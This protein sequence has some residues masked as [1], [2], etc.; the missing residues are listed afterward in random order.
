MNNSRIAAAAM[1]LGLLTESLPGEPATVSFLV[2]V[3]LQCAWRC[4]PHACQEI[5][6]SSGSHVALR[7]FA[8]SLTI[9]RAGGSSFALNTADSTQQ[10]ALSVYRS[11]SILPDVLQS[12][13]GLL[14]KQIDGLTLSLP[15][16]PA[17]GGNIPSV[18]VTVPIDPSLLMGRKPGL[19]TVV[20]T[21]WDS[22]IGAFSTDG[23]V[24]LKWLTKDMYLC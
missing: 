2:Y 9:P 17:S 24:N 13:F 14:S 8:G 10:I 15:V 6:G 18:T 11:S 21:Y 7:A 20:C 23:W 16:G 4:T 12:R 5:N 3:R 22:S 1:M 19:Q